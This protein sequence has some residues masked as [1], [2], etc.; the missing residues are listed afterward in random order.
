MVNLKTHCEIRDQGP[1]YK[2]TDI[3]IFEPEKG[4]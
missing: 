3:L 2:D 4:T 1:G